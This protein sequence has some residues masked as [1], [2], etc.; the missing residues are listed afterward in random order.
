MRTLD[1]G[2]RRKLRTRRG[3]R[4]RF[5]EKRKRAGNDGEKLIELPAIDSVSRVTLLVHRWQF[6]STA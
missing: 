3:R 4:R 2:L 5:G 1:E 6:S